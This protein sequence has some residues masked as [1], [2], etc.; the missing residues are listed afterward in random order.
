M[1][2]TTKKPVQKKQ[3]LIISAPFVFIELGCP[4]IKISFKVFCIF[5][6]ILSSYLQNTLELYLLILPVSFTW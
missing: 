6:S 4:K 2:I 1:F 5:E 3:L